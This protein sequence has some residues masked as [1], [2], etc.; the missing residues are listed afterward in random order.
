MHIDLKEDYSRVFSYLKKR[1]ADYPASDSEGP[2]ES[3]APITQMNFGFQ[4]D[5]A[6]WVAWVVD[7]RPDAE[8]DGEWNSYIE[9]NCLELNHWFK[10]VDEL[11]E[12]NTP[13]TLNTHNESTLEIDTAIEMEE[14]ASHFGNMLRDVLLEARSS[15][16]FGSLPLSKQCVMFIEEHDSLYG[17]PEYD[18]LMVDGLVQ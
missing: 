12:N 6:G 9:K 10:A 4:F 14:L 17:W 16:L 2:G 18:T 3:S 5:Q 15:G 7:T 1:I 11:F 13:F 8:P